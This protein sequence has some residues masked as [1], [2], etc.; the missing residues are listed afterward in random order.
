MGF[1]RRSRYPLN[2][3]GT[4]LDGLTVVAKPCTFDEYIEIQN[5][6]SRD[7]NSWDDL[8]RDFHEVAQIMVPHLVS[9]DL[10]IVVDEETGELQDVPLTVESFVSQDRQFQEALVRAYC[11]AVSE[12]PRPLETRSGSGEQS[13]AESLPM[14]VLSGSQAS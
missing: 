9:W 6:R 7:C 5:I 1:V 13:L 2:F 3:A 11:T 10:Q 12:V 14:E 8:K 4:D